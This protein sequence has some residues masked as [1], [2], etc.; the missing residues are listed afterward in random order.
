MASKEVQTL[1]IFLYSIFVYIILPV[2]KNKNKV[3][4]GQKGKI[5]L[6]FSFYILRLNFDSLVTDSNIILC[7]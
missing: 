3:D 5:W 4:I 2:Q 1:E 6:S 7:K